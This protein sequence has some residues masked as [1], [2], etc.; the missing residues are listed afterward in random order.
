M[1]L[2]VADPPVLSYLACSSTL[3]PAIVFQLSAVAALV[4]LALNLQVYCE[5]DRNCVL[6]P[7]TQGL[8]GAV[9]VVFVDSRTVA[10]F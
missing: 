6:V 7:A 4:V 5:S 8:A 2:G 10:V 1:V 9:A 3:T